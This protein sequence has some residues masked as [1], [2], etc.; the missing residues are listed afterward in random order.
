MTDTAA[1][2][3]SAAPLSA[4]PE[5]NV[6]LDDRLLTIAIARPE[7]KNALTGD[8]YRAITAALRSADDD[9]AVGAVILTGAAGVFTAGNDIKDF[10]AAGGEAG[11]AAAMDLLHAAAGLETPLVAAVDGLAIGIG[12]TILLHC[13]FAYAT[14]ATRFKTPFVDLGLCPEG[15][16]T[17]LMPEV[18]GR[19]LTKAFLL[20]GRE[21]GPEEAARGGLIDGVADDA[22]AAAR[23]TAAALAAKPKNAMR[24]AKRLLR[25]ARRGAVSE[26]IDREALAFRD[27]LRDPETQRIVAGFFAGKR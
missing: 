7:K 22:M 23:E 14:P 8:M 16:S 17:V 21:V 19:S 9:P 12:T 4:C 2:A 20:L 15:A 3:R 10:V 27:R 24:A 18:L 5:V 6:A 1:D 11:P 13:D 26:A 25:D